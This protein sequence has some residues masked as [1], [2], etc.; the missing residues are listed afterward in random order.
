MLAA[1]S[2]RRTWLAPAALA[3]ALVAGGCSDSTDPDDGDHA[4][5]AGLV[6]E[7]GGVEVVTVNADRVV[8]GSFTVAAGEETDH[9]EVRFLDEDGEVIEIDEAEFYLAV[10][11]DDDGIAGIEQHAPGEF[12]VHVVGV[13]TGTTHLRFMLMHG[14]HPDGHADYTSPDIPVTVTVPAT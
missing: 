14:Q 8:T 12:E 6:A 5:P 10:E 2:I 11:V 4:E 1:P 9:V 13:A 3:L 7:I